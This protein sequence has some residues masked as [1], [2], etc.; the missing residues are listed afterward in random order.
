MRFGKII[1]AFIF[2]FVCS[3]PHFVF[4]GNISA[5]DKYARF[6]DGSD[7]I[8]FNPSNGNV[9]VSTTTLTGHAWGT[10]SSWI[11]LAPTLGG[12]VND[13][14]GNLSGYAWGENTGWINFDPTNGG[15]TIDCNGDFSG[16]A[17]AE[18]RGWIVFNCST[19][20]SCSTL[21]HKVS[22]TWNGGV[23][24]AS[25][26]QCNDGVDNDNDGQIDFGTDPGC[27][28]ATDDDE[29]NGGGSSGPP[30]GGPQPQC[31]DNRDNDGDGLVDRFDH[32]CH[33]DG[34]PNNTNS[35]SPNTNNENARP[36]LTLIG[37]NQINIALGTP[38]VDL[39]ATAQ[40]AEDG[41]ITSR[42]THTASLVNV[43]I[44]G[45]YVVIYNVADSSGF[46]AVPIT[47][48]VKVI[49]NTI[50]PPPPPDDLDNNPPII[51]LSGFS[52][53]TIQ[54]GTQFFEP[55][56]RALD[57]EDGDI[58]FSV[59]VSS[60]V[61]SNR[62]GSYV[63]TYRVA[64]SAGATHTVTRIVDVIPKGTP[65]PPPPDGEVL[66]PDDGVPNVPPPEELPGGEDVFFPP[67]PVP[68]FLG[69]VVPLVNDTPAKAFGIL[70]LILGLIS[71]FL[72]V[73]GMSGK[74]SELVLLPARIWSW[75]LSF[76]G[77]RKRYRPWGTVYDAITKQPLDPAYVTLLGEDGTE[78]ATSIT[79][80]DGRYGF[81]APAGK[82][83]LKAQKT[84]YVFPS[85][86][87]KGKDHDELYNN[88]YF[89]ETIE[90]N[91][92]E[93]IVARNIPMDPVNFDWNEFAKKGHKV[94]HVYSKF[95]PI[96][97]RLSD[98]F[99]YVGLVVS[100]FAFYVLPAPYNTII[101]VLY[102]VMLV[103]RILGLRPRFNGKIVEAQTGKPLSFAIIRVKSPELALLGQ[104]EVA[105]R[106]ADALGRYY[107]LVPIGKYQ[108]TVE[109]KN[110]DGSYSHIYTSSVFYARKGIINKTFKV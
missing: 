86:K 6:L 33:T 90:L 56:F 17:W 75:L 78:V 8:N 77:L 82:Y 91:E 55:G 107:L 81:L 96:F 27:S 38:Y 61:N 102:I 42:I 53:V 64:D 19:D 44:P 26:F 28:G 21:N 39:G 85:E 97:T 106:V 80:I 4:A 63:V 57:I 13:G 109:K 36:V 11:N 71:T 76:F 1:F 72:S 99:F 51:T 3:A 74:A 2:L 110:S 7:L 5:T 12:V 45:D 35:Y 34:N 47:R 92:K 95:D 83:T 14:S 66:P 88:L 37:Q 9:T 32:A 10:N 93:G 68:D 40:D 79:D 31:S 105:K 94:M 65:L 54:E 25:T 20:N 103:L 59:T 70:G 58:T 16:Y 29:V 67:G 84:N 48:I 43:N 60:L 100:V 30:G 73:L 108:I 50:E 62:V 22:T 46:F 104:A 18:K 52:V 89:G 15:V 49:S 24:V 69:P 98:I 41:N 101:F 23:C 87:L